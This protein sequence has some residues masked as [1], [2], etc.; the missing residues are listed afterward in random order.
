MTTN[1]S[2]LYDNY[3]QATQVAHALRA[4]G[5]PH[6][7]ISIISHAGEGSEP[8]SE[9][10]GGASTGAGV[11]AVIGGGAGLAA[12]LGVLAIPGLGPVVAAGWLAATLTGAVAGAVTG[13]A[14]GGLIGALTDSGIPEA[15]AHVY[16]ESIRRGGAM[17]V[18]RTKEIHRAA[19]EAVLDRHESVSLVDRRA[20]FVR[21]GWDRYEDTDA[22]YA[23]RDTDMRRGGYTPI[24]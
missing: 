5:I 17:V 14:A 11:G 4:S 20:M 21:D 9:A 2:R 1:V 13:A 8:V 19:A 6:D 23:A 22:P 10:G 16:A 24:L 7:D 3:A 15:D 18:V 12:G